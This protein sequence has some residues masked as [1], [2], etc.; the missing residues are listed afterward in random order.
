MQV[1]YITVKGGPKRGGSGDSKRGSCGGGGGG[2]EEIAILAFVRHLE[3]A[4]REYC[5][6]MRSNVLISDVS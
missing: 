4:C 1:A 3:F 6:E 2:G 5:Y